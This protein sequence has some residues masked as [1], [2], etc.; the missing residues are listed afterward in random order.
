MLARCREFAAECAARPGKGWLFLET[1][2]GPHSPHIS[3]RTQA[4]V[5]IPLRAPV[6]LVADPGLGGISQ[7]IAAFESLLLRGY[8]VESVVLFKND[9]YENDGYLGDYFQEHHRLPV[10]SVAGPP[11]KGDE[12]RLDSE[13]MMEYYDR[14]DCQKAACQILEHLKLRHSRR[15][16]SLE[17]LPARAH[18]HIW[19]PFTQQSLLG[20]GDIMAI[21]SAHGDCFQSL[22]AAADDGSETPLLQSSFDGSASWWTQGL[23]HSN[24][25]L[26]L[27]A[28]SAA[29]RYGHVMFAGAIHEPAMALAEAL[30]RAV[31]NPRQSRV[32]YSDNGSTGNEVALKMALRAARLRHK[33]D[34]RQKLGVIGIKGGYH[35]DTLGA[36]D[37]TEPSAF[38][39]K[40]E[41]YES[42]GYWFDS[43]TVLCTN[44]RWSVSG[45]GS[46]L[47]DAKCF[48]SLEGIFDVEARERREEH[49]PYEEHII[50]TLYRLGQQERRFGAVML[51][52]VVMGAGGM[53][54]V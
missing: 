39:E 29:G 14:V 4:D 35:G 1:A 46:E 10:T 26:T 7:T 8:Q 30:L 33:P 53:K 38:S 17:A 52:P 51:E 49:K 47:G 45:G 11:R 28:A 37:A 42:R 50:E 21:D 13:A 34:A 23:G 16:A 54:L 40:V 27:A 32:F 43:P 15:I 22:R 18:R 2:G 12:A 44:G 31:D 6:V 25:R 19:Y 48:P 9:I 20:P 24:P 5:Y 41:W 3:G 36:M